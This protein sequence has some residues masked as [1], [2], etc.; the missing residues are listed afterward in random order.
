[1]LMYN[2]KTT[3]VALGAATLLL[4]ANVHAA[5]KCVVDGKTTEAR[6]AAKAQKAG[7]S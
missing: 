2:T 4:S 7:M 5:Y 1:M 6:L 3:I